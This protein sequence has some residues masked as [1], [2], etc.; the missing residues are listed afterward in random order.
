[1]D[2]VS[3]K[4]LTDS[5]FFFHSIEELDKIIIDRDILL[6]DYKYEQIKYL[7]PDL[8]RELSSSYLT[9]LQNNAEKKQKWPLLNLVRQILHFY[10]FRMKPLRKSDGNTL[11]GI[12]KYKRMFQIEKI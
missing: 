6:C 1:M 5:G 3:T 11:D 4:I 10:H 8:K 2:E 9:S 12:K 7:I